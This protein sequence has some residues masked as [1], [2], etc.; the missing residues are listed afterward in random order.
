MASQTRQ[1]CR[2]A[3]NSLSYQKSNKSSGPAAKPVGISFGDTRTRRT[4][5]EGV[6]VVPDS[7]AECGGF[8]HLVN[9]TTSGEMGRAGIRSSQKP[10]ASKSLLSAHPATRCHNGR[11][12]PW[13]TS[14]GGRQR[15]GVPRR[16]KGQAGT[17]RAQPQPAPSTSA[18]RARRAKSPAEWRR[19]YASDLMTFQPW[20][21]AGTILHSRRA[22]SKDAGQWV[23]A[24]SDRRLDCGRGALRAPAGA[25]RAPLHGAQWAPPQKLVQARGELL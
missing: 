12:E 4:S 14:A 13:R 20:N 17:R 5:V 8:A 21:Y 25:Q 19:Q 10:V 11:R 2:Q 7:P 1:G 24:V 15:V 23:P 3:S 6:W 18:A 22:R 9:G 16:C